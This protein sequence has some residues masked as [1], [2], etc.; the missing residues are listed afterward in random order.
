MSILRKFYILHDF[1]DEP[2]FTREFTPYH[3]NMLNALE[4]AARMRY[5]EGTLTE[6]TSSYWEFEYTRDDR[7]QKIRVRMTDEFLQTNTKPQS[8]GRALAPPRFK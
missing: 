2:E 7:R 8:R 4:G 3:E 1:I 5:T 6:V